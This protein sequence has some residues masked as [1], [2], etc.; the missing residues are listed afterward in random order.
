MTQQA[1]DGDR[2]YGHSD[3]AGRMPLADPPFIAL[4]QRHFSHDRFST[5]SFERLLPSLKEAQHRLP[6]SACL[7]P[8]TSSVH[9]LYQ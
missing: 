9:N 7:A 6:T 5:V 2:P 1:P 3:A 8:T 4:H